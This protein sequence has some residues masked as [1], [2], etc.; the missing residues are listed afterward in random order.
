MWDDDLKHGEGIY[1]DADKVVHKEIWDH[2]KL[3]N[4]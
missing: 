2:G 1:K 3:V 4:S